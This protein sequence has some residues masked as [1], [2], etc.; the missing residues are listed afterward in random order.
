MNRINKG[1]FM[2]LTMRVFH[3]FRNKERR[4]KLV[5]QIKKKK[6]NKKKNLLI[7]LKGD[8]II[9]EAGAPEGSGNNH[10]V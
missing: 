5:K 8:G 2:E 7:H 9:Q 1:I 10:G 6:G 3:P 4:Q